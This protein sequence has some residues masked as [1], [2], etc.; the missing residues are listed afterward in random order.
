MAAL[1]LSDDIIIAKIR[2]ASAGG[3]LQFDTGVDGL[4]GLKAAVPAHPTTS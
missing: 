4:K 2:G 1:G 3:T